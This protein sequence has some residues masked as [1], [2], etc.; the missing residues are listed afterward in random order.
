MVTTGHGTGLEKTLD[1]L[2][3]TESLPFIIGEGILSV[4]SSQNDGSI[5]RGPLTTRWSYQEPVPRSGHW[6][7]S[8]PESNS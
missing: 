4:G 5:R 1:Y 6:L 2:I 3:N 8:S 7:L